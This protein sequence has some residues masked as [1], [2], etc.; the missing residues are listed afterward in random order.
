[1]RR[2]G[3]FALAAAMLLLTAC[4]GPPATESPPPEPSPT[5]TAAP[6]PEA[7]DFALGYAGGGSLH[8]LKAADQSSLDVDSLVYEGLYRL[9]ERFEAK[10][11]L[12]QSAS[13]SGDGLT[14]TVALRTD[15]AFSDGTALMAEHVA[16]SLRAAMGSALYAARMAGITSIRAGE[17]AVTI[18]LSAPNGTLP[19]LLTAPVTLDA[20]GELPLGTGP[21]VF[22]GEGE[23]LKLAANPNWWQ[24]R[25]PSF[26]TIPLRAYEML[27]DRISAFDSGL[28]TA[29]TNDFTA[30]GALG[31]SGT[32][33]THDYLSPI[34]LFV[35]FNTMK[36]PCA[37][38]NV[39]AALSRAFDRMSIVSVLLS[40]HGEAAALPVPP[41]SGQY[42]E[43][44]AALLDY[45]LTAA[46]ELLA[47]AG[48]S[49]NEEGQLIRRRSALSLTLAVNRDSVVKCSIA[50]YIA[51][52][53]TE[54][55]MAVTVSELDW[56]DYTAALTA[57]NFDLYLGEVKLTADFD[58]TALVSGGLNYGGYENAELSALL[59]AWRAASGDSRTAA[60]ET[61]FTAMAADLPFAPL[62][63]KDRSL[64]VRWG[65]VESLAP[66]WGAP[67]AGVESWQTN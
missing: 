7:A 15:A 43:T 22:D 44:A 39:R 48:C 62:C 66:V 21:Y 33:E 61:L 30:S 51:K 42:S 13:V 54:L 50:R 20:G 53:L 28:V 60:A 23:S 57:G 12:A 49:R 3:V 56:N 26:D 17:G 19:V 37:D 46:E 41:V 34:M 59:A 27:D 64:L 29:V 55:G 45:D 10:P 31:Y 65:M 38:P 11:V 5:A 63:F 6:A 4:G 52:N 36:G 9:D 18:T 8:P 47:A 24:G 58:F 40:G 14:W 32:Y 25:R 67:F 16:A 2:R 35:G 1:M